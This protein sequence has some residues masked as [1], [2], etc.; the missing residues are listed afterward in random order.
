[1]QR[2]H[3]DLKILWSVIVFYI[4]KQSKIR[5]VFIPG[6]AACIISKLFY[7][8]SSRTIGDIA[9]KLSSD[10]SVI[11]TVFL[12]GMFLF[13]S[14]T[15]NQLGKMFVSRARHIGYT[16]ANKQSYSYFLH[17]YPEDFR[18]IKKG[19]M[20]NI[21]QRK[22]DAVKDILDVL[23][24]HFLPFLVTVVVAGAD[25]IL[26]LGVFANIIVL[27]T[28]FI[29]IFVTISITLW[30]NKI[31][32]T[33][34]N[35]LDNSQNVLNDGINNFETI[36]TNGTETYEVS[37]YE[38]CLKVTEK[39]EIFF[40]RT[41]Y[42]L[43]LAQEVIWALQLF[44]VVFLLCI[45]SKT[46]TVDT[47]SYTVTVL[48]VFHG[49]L[50]NLGFMYGKY[51]TGMINIK[52]TNL[53]TRK[54]NNLTKKKVSGIKKQIKIFDLSYKLNDKII[55]DSINFEI[56]KGDKIAIIGHNGSGKSSLLKCILKYN[57][58]DIQ[59]F[60]DDVNIQNISEEDFKNLFAYVSQ[61]SSLFNE[62]VMYN[63]KYTNKK[64]YEEQIYNAANHLTVHESIMRL[65]NGY[66]T[67]CGE[68]G[69]ALS[70]GERQKIS[71]LRAYLKNAGILVLDEAT[72]SMDIKSEH[73][74]FEVITSDKKLTCIAIVHN[75]DLLKKFNRILLVKDKK[76]I[77]ISHEKAEKVG[78]GKVN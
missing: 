30:R 8:R 71:I 56:N 69:S 2:N 20:Q 66:H 45:V 39:N 76:V 25:I 53:K 59:M 5:R 77:E 17:L 27:T 68:N 15:T 1:M 34:N 29:Y 35:N 37:K 28:L 14:C 49:D 12:Y 4:I 19:E 10:E 11:K 48:S 23:T 26:K 9:K 65:K 63:I 40:S 51:K 72:A 70:G 50:S 54:D 55:L 47:L 13:L 46:M 74:I 32:I 52:K 21:I 22:A 64:V 44:L 36:F 7:I 75:L 57:T 38:K 18:N 16:I 58:S 73:N 42:F 61:S 6:L 3:S 60:V 41:M 33:L 43:N 62:S 78:F 67:L 24:L 31:R